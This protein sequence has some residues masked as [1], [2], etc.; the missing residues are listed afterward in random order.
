MKEGLFLLENRKCS[1]RGCADPRE[2]SLSLWWEWEHLCS[3]WGSLQQAGQ[4]VTGMSPLERGRSSRAAPRER[5]RDQGGESPSAPQI[6]VWILR[7]S[8]APRR[9]P[10]HG[11]GSSQPCLVFW[12]LWGHP[13]S[14]VEGLGSGL[15]SPCKPRTLLK[16]V[17]DEK[18]GMSF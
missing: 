10:G 16:G 14:A 7:P 11:V 8:P 3:S 18:L 5:D 12:D 13:E 4:E 9:L 2:G 1:Q 17:T 6:L 15:C